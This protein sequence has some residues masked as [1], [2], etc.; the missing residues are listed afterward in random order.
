M[1]FTENMSAGLAILGTG[2]AAYLWSQGSS[3]M[4][5]VPILYFTLMEVLQYASYVA[6][7]KKDKFALKKLTFATFVH[8]AF[9]PVF[10]LLW[11]GNFIPPGMRPQL[12]LLLKLAGAGGA[13]YAARSDQITP[14]KESDVCNPRTETMC[15]ATSLIKMGTKHLAY[16]F[17]MRAPDYTTPSIFIHFF[18]MF[19]AP[20]FLH[21]KPIGYLPVLLGW[22][23][24]WLIMPREEIAATW[25]LI[26]IPS[27]LVS[28][29]VRPTNTKLIR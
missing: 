10:T 2:V 23:T 27:L 26:S 3:W 6:M 1:C 4:L 15:G 14:I 21:V 17:R 5:Y 16:L 12:R 25:C 8:V 19:V 11:M 24:S 7:R 13:F 29:F 20:L 22:I 28:L 9:Q 18:L